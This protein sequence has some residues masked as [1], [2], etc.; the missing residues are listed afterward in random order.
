VARL[1][2]KNSVITRTSFEKA[3]LFGIVRIT[4]GI[5]AFSHD[6][7]I[8]EKERSRFLANMARKL[9]AEGP[10]MIFVRADLL[11]DAMPV[12]DLD[13]SSNEISNLSESSS[14]SDRTLCRKLS[15]IRYSA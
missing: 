5:V 7:L 11:A 15:P 12:E 10:D 4:E 6:R 2:S 9:E 1:F 14:L 8:A 3:R 13:W